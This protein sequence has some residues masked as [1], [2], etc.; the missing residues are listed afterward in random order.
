MPGCELGAGEA[1]VRRAV[2]SLRGHKQS[3]GQPHPLAVPPRSLVWLGADLNPALV[4]QVGEVDESREVISGQS[5]RSGKRQ[6]CC[7]N[8]WNLLIL[9][10]FSCLLFP[11]F[12][13]LLFL[14]RLFGYSPFKIY[15]LSWL[16][17]R[18]G[19][20]GN[21]CSDCLGQRE[22]QAVNPVTRCHGHSTKQDRKTQKGCTWRPTYTELSCSILGRFCFLLRMET[23]LYQEPAAFPR[24]IA[25]G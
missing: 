24:I 20:N 23:I 8:V 14:P 7:C 21:G 18:E 13:S 11:G 17:Q 15:S 4:Q 22:S 1:N 19:E 10:S 12:G 9:V 25:L 16:S 3:A 6:V 5:P 2:P